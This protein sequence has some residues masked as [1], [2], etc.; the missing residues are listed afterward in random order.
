MHE[1][2]EALEIV[3]TSVNGGKL[4]RS[5]AAVTIVD[6]DSASVPPPA[7]PRRRTSAH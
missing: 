3:L 4:D 6:D 1:S 2:L 7:P 5:V